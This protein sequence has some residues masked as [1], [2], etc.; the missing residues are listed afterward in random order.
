MKPDEAE[1]EYCRRTLEWGKGSVESEAYKQFQVERNA[2]FAAWN[3]QFQRPDRGEALARF[4]KAC[5]PE[6]PPKAPTAWGQFKAL[7][8]GVWG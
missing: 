5:I 3:A 7:L 4:Q 1:L 2:Q 6:R 8:K